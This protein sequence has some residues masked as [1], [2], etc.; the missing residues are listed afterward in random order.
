MSLQTH[1]Q[2]DFKTKFVKFKLNFKV[3][4]QFKMEYNSYGLIEEVLY[5][6]NQWSLF[7]HGTDIKFKYTNQAHSL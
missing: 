3:F 2:I 7:S 4:L 6:F 1:F 5:R